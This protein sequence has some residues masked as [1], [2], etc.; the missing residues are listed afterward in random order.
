VCSSRVH[1]GVH[2]GGASTI[3]EFLVYN[4][5]ECITRVQNEGASTIYEFLTTSSKI[6]FWTNEKKHSKDFKTW[7][8]YFSVMHPRL[9]TLTKFAYLTHSHLI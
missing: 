5:E 4:L 6:I 2:N 7:K 9:C 1:N 3:Y 8:K